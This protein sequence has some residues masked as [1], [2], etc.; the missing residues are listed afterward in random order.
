MFHPISRGCEFRVAELKPK[1]RGLALI[2][3]VVAR[4]RQTIDRY[5][6]NLAAMQNAFA[7]IFSLPVQLA[8]AS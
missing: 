4:L 6:S 5:D 7:I 8:I 2:I 1:G 3:V